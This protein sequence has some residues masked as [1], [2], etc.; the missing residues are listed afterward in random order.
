MSQQQFGSTGQCQ[1]SGVRKSDWDCW[2]SEPIL[3]R[4]KIS[5]AE[6]VLEGWVEAG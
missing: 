3:L 5:A 1:E 4:G 6:V 2:K